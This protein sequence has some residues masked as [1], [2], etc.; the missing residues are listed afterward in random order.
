M[1]Q[2]NVSV[3][4]VFSDGDHSFNANVWHHNKKTVVVG[5]V[6]NYN[7]GLLA[8]HMGQKNMSMH[9]TFIKL[10]TDL[11]ERKFSSQLPYYT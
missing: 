8:I 4:V 11:H 6:I 7:R 5:W 3:T 2:Y 1:L 9:D 10:F